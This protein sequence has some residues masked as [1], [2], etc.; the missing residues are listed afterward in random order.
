MVLSRRPDDA[1]PCPTT[2]SPNAILDSQP[3]WTGDFQSP[4]I[5]D[6][7]RKSHGA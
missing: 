2:A 1:R 3:P 4:R 7:M 6:P 5:R